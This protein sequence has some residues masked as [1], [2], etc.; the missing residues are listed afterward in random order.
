MQLEGE[1]C[2]DPEYCDG[3]IRQIYRY[4]RWTGAPH[5]RAEVYFVIRRDG[6][7]EDLRIVRPSG[8]L[9]FDFEAMGAIEQAGRRKAFGPLPP[10]FGRD[11]LPILFEF[12]PPG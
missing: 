9:E 2:P 1:Q 12:R 8:S 3:I 6:S 11:R 4:F 10:A 5:L 7:V